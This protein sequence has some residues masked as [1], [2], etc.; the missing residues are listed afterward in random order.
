MRLLQNPIEMSEAIVM[1]IPE[2][3]NPPSNNKTR[4]LMCYVL[5]AFFLIFFIVGV[6]FIAAFFALESKL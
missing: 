5:L 4:K 6:I 3:V 2:P 1:P